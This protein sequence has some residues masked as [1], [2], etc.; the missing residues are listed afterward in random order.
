M[1]VKISY[2]QG[3]E[4]LGHELKRSLIE[5][6]CIIKT[7]PAYSGNTQA[8]A[9]I[10]RIHQLLGNLV[11]F[12]NLQETCVDDADPCMGILAAA[13]FEVRSTYH[14]TEKNPVPI[15]FWAR[16]DTPN[17]SY[18]ELEIHMSAETNTDQKIRNF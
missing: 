15:S 18:S 16:K 8:N 2:D 7:K 1:Q 4:L 6:K 3:G 17:Q 12:Y 13:A 9:T 14:R 5:Q 10:E 11:R